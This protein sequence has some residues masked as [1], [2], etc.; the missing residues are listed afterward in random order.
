MSDGENKRTGNSIV[1]QAFLHSDDHLAV[2][3]FLSSL[4]EVE[5]LSG[6]PTWVPDCGLRQVSAKE[7]QIVKT[8]YTSSP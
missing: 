4:K 5:L 8:G 6:R 3:E 7:C 2:N 1:G